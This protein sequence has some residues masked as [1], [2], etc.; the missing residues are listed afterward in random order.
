MN[1]F[2]SFFLG[3]EEPRSPR[4]A[5]AQK[6]MRVSGHLNDLETV[7]PSPY[8]HTFFEM[9]GNWSFGDYFKK[10]A[11]AWAWE[12]VTE[13]LKLPRE[14]LWTTV[15]L[16][17]DEAARLWREQGVPPDRIVRLGDKDNFWGPAGDSGP[18]GRA[19]R[20]FMTSA[21]VCCVMSAGMEAGPCWLLV[22]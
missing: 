16:D 22:P 2:K 13:W 12:F 5:D 19:A 10:E 18:A 8:H 4:V 3:L 20:F 17:D 11:I 7:G 14:R 21:K 15:F 1:Q 9:M 6:C